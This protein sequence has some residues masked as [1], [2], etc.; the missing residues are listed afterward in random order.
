MSQRLKIS[1]YAL[2]DYNKHI[3]DQLELPERADKDEIVNS[4]LLETLDRDVLYKDPGFMQTA[5][6]VWSHKKMEEWQ[7]L[8]EALQLEYNPIENYDRTEDESE[9]HRNSES[10]SLTGTSENE[11]K[12]SAYNSSD[13]QPER[14]QT[15]T[16][17]DSGVIT[18]QGT[19]Q[20]GSR[21]HGNI[22]VTTST[23]LLKEYI[24]YRGKVCF[25][26]IVIND[27]ISEFIRLVY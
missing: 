16:A 24:D 18:D 1:L 6:G 12:V 13:Y 17:T 2:Y 9:A 25:A 10:R 8:Y 3:F 27:F 19:I 7:L 22:G 5:I 20:R 23:F 11:S 26:D 15:G 14:K 4:L 21:I